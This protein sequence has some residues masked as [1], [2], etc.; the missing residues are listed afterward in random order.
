MNKF[1]K[2]DDLSFARKLGGCA[3][4]LVLPV[5]AG[6]ALGVFCSG[7]GIIPF[8]TIV[9]VVAPLVGI[10]SNYLFLKVVKERVIDE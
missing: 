7:L 1:D 4:L 8:L 10:V 5:S 9:A 6:I 2:F 3:T